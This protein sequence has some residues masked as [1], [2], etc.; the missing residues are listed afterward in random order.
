MS[1]LLSGKLS[2]LLARLGTPASSTVAAKVDTLHD[3]RLTATRAGYLDNLTDLDAPI[4][5]IAAGGKHRAVKL[6]SGAAWTHPVNVKDNR[7]L[8][9]L[10][11]A[12]GA[13]GRE[14]NAGEG[15]GGGGGGE[16]IFRQP[17]I[18]SGSSTSTS[19]PAAT[20]GRATDG[21]GATGAD[22]TF[23]TLRARGGVGGGDTTNSPPSGGL[24]GGPYQTSYTAGSNVAQIGLAIGC[25]IGGGE[26]G[27]GDD[28]AGGA[29][30]DGGESLGL[31]GAF[32][33]NCGGGGGSWGAGGPGVTTGGSGANGTEGGGGGGCNSG[34]SGAGGAG[35][36]LIE[37]EEAS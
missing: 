12:G 37:Y 27:K 16:T 10:V 24:P 21:I 31:G 33:S 5:G 1:I 29:A 34:N 14:S 9:S 26:G 22:C 32:Q 2:R 19:I 25:R 35:F 11:A 17:Y 28:G 20:A 13:G 15:G 18:L 8:V 3:S 23:G 7:V 6:T 36:I 4:S 30:F